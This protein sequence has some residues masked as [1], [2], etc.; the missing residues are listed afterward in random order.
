VRVVESL[1][2]AVAA[3]VTLVHPGDAIIT[4]G[5]GSIGSLPARIVEALRQERRS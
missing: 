2:A 1:D 4:M 5:A 3:V